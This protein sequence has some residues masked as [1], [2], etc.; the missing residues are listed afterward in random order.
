LILLAATAAWFCQQQL[1][2]GF[3]SSD[4]Y[5]VLNFFLV[6]VATAIVALLLWISFSFLVP[7][8]VA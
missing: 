4:C 2:L 3:V 8:T 6:L 7:E 5:F 1:W